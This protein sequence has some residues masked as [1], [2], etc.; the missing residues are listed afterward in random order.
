MPTE[1]TDAP[2]AQIPMDA[3]DEA[4]RDQFEAALTALTGGVALTGSSESM[5]ETG[6]SQAV[7]DHKAVE[8][9]AIIADAS[10]RAKRM[11]ER[12]TKKDRY[13]LVYDRN[14]DVSEVRAV[15]A[16]AKDED[17]T[18][19]GRRLQSRTPSGRK[20][21]DTSFRVTRS[22]PDRRHF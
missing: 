4:T 7:G 12:A 8:E 10:E 9:D 15:K 11:I 21:N 22:N 1:T 13:E 18:E 3:L 14:G 20:Q 16:V 19:A 5:Y 17:A 2:I 6:L